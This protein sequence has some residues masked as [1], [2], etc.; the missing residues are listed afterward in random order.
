MKV[1]SKKQLLIQ[2][3]LVWFIEELLSSVLPEN[4]LSSFA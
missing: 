2:K 4:F 1:K 3:F